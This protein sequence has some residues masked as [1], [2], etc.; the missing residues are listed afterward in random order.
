MLPFTE[1]MTSPAKTHVYMYLWVIIELG[2]SLTYI[3]RKP[4]FQPAV[5]YRPSEPE[6]H[7]LSIYI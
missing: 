2:T 4:L 1:G 6:V 5:T 7:I 3:L